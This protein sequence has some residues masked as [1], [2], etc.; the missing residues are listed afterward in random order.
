MSETTIA[1]V[2]SVISIVVITSDDVQGRIQDVLI[3]RSALALAV[4]GSWLRIGDW[5]LRS[6][7]VCLLSGWTGNR[8]G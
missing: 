2:S 5:Y 3:V 1:E 6:L 8:A 7:V 4:S